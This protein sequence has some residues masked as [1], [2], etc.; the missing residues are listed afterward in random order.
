MCGLHLELFYSVRLWDVDED[1]GIAI[2]LHMLKSE[3]R[4]K[5][6]VTI[7]RINLIRNA[8]VTSLGVLQC[9]ASAHECAT[10]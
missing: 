4:L 10:F 5:I 9:V 7:G 3:G 2:C 6:C 1:V 8:D